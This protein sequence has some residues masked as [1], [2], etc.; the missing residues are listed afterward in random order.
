[1]ANII[2][3]TNETEQ[4]KYSSL[5]KNALSHRTSSSAEIITFGCQ[6][7]EADSEKIAGLCSLMGFDTNPAGSMS[8]DEISDAGLIIINTCAIRE[9]AE[10]KALSNT[11]RLKKLKETNPELIVGI[12]GCMVQ[13]KHRF[14]QIKKSYPYVDFM[15]GTD[16][17]HKLPEV[18]W[19][20]LSEQRRIYGV[21]DLPH[22]E[23]GVIEENMPVLRK[24]PFKVWVPI[25]YG[26]NNFCTYC[27]VPRVRGHERSRSESAIIE[28]VKT[29]IDGGC[30]EITLLGQNVNSY[31]G[32]N[33]GFVK[34]LESLLSLDGDFR[35][36]FMTSHPKDASDELIELMNHPKMAKHF[37]LPFQAGSDRILKL[38]NRRY[39]KEKY[40]ERALK[41]R[42]TSPDCAITTDVICGFPGETAEEFEETLEVVR[43]VEFD[44]LFSF[45][46]SPRKGTPAAKFDDQISHDEKIRRFEKLTRLTNSIS[47]KRNALLVG[48]TERVLCDTEADSEGFSSGKSSQNKLIKFYNPENQ[49]K[50]G[51]FADVKIT[52]AF[53]AS[54]NGKIL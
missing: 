34:L 21:S 50:V 48:K 38:M 44:T 41:I 13:E 32:E 43:A 25:M 14:D 19:R 20:V 23:L 26:C 9:H 5:V 49:I 6:Q 15:L 36:R 46:F 30:K 24:S 3:F 37:H 51:E 35:L 2:D 1:M 8:S 54:L 29:L 4:A 11:G 18:L 10:L 53:R 42:Q 33:G 7:N 39:T 31:S 22:S 28:E 27:V 52:E 17:I 40:L 12:C 16:S 45:V 47:E